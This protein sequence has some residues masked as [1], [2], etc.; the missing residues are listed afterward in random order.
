MGLIDAYHYVAEITALDGKPIDQLPVQPDWDAALQWS[1]FQAVRRGELPPLMRGSSATVEPLWNPQLGEPH[2]SAFH[3]IPAGVGP[4]D[5]STSTNSHP[6]REVLG[7]TIPREYLRSEVERCATRLLDEGKLLDGQRF[8]YKLSAFPKQKA[9]EPAAQPQRFRVEEVEQVLPLRTASLAGYREGASLQLPTSSA[10]SAESH[11]ELDV[12]VFVPERVLAEGKALARAAGG[13]ETGGVLIGHLFRD[14][15][16]T[17]I[18]SVITAFIPAQHTIADQS[19]LTFTAET[20]SAVSAA[21]E[22]RGREEILLGHLHSH[23]FWCRDC[24]PERRQVCPLMR[25]FFS[26]DD[27]ALHRTVFAGAFHIAVLLSDLGGDDLCCDMFGWRYG[28]VMSRSYYLTGSGAAS[29][30]SSSASRPAIPESDPPSADADAIAEA[31]PGSARS[32]AKST[33]HPE[34][35][36]SCST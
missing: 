1:H 31:T 17:D 14:S 29:L 19:R 8:L 35:G 11:A 25:P 18:F 26:R 33:V 7:F 27:I 6:P 24:P 2:V 9:T 28:M 10:K 12:P 30:Q 16:G 21:V 15:A 4:T 13:I 34:A 20:W 23:P 3:V 36:S 22:L 5:V 32:S